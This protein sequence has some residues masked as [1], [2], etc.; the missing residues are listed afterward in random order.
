[1]AESA[2]SIEKRVDE[3]EFRIAF[4]E[5]TLTQ[6]NDVIAQQR[7]EI[8]HLTQQLSE[9]IDTL[10]STMQT[11]GSASDVDEKPPHY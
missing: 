6:L 3:L 9:V 7:D 10:R 11:G 8:D 5:D 1:M 2:Q 4:Q